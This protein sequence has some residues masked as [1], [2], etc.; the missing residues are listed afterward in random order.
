MDHAP[1]YKTRM[2]EKFYC[3]TV[4]DLVRQLERLNDLLERL[5][6]GAGARPPGEPRQDTNQPDCFLC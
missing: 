2:G 6:V 1:F 5:L 3:K 4:P